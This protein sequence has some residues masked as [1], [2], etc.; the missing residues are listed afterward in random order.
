MSDDEGQDQ[1]HGL[2]I[3]W[4]ME[5]GLQP[6][7]SGRLLASSGG[8]EIYLVFFTRRRRLYLLVCSSVVQA[9]GLSIYCQGYG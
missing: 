9:W 3:A 5:M 6:M 4:G 1:E 7:E 2:V 8:R